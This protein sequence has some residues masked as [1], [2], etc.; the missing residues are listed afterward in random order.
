MNIQDY[1]IT[2]DNLRYCK[3][4]IRNKT[5]HVEDVEHVDSLPSNGKVFTLYILNN[6][7]VFYYGGSMFV[8]VELEKQ[9]PKLNKKN[10]KD[11]EIVEISEDVIEELE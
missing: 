9:K 2:I 6:G 4:V 11:K 7:K 1:V 5:I 8:Q 3:D 10:K